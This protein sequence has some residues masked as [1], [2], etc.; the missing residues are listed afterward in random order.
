M[1]E[2]NPAMPHHDISEVFPDV[3][4][5]T[6]TMRGEFFGSQWQFNRNM[7]IVR[8]NGN[9]SLIN[10]VRLNE[11]GLAA[12]DALGPVTNIIKIGSMHGHDDAFY[13]DRYDAAYWAMPG[14]P[15]PDGV[16]G[17]KELVDGG[18]MP[19]SDCTLFTFTTTKLPEGILFLGR[20]GGIAISCDSLQNWLTH[21][22]LFFESTVETMREMGFFT[23][24]NLG[25]AWMHVSEPRADDF[26]RL[27]DVSFRHALCGH[28]EPLRNTAREDFAATFQR[29]FQVQAGPA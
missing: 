25:P 7:I 15:L 23:K 18:Q 28:G 20:E 5:V 1:S 8:D 12:L 16:Q 4:F 19:F 22:D 9:L 14:M 17:A 11:Q 3:F 24:A 21:D 27:K 6:G 26:V 13:M 29:I 10:A 2:F